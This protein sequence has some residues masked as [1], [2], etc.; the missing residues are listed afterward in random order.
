[1]DDI[2]RC[3]DCGEARG[4]IHGCDFAVNIASL[5]CDQCGASVLAT[6]TDL[7]LAWHKEINDAFLGTVVMF[8]RMTRTIESLSASLEDRQKD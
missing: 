3:D 7:H 4:P 5:S 6:E 2:T 8:E 1:M